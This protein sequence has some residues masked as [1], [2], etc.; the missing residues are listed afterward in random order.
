MK[1]LVPANSLPVPRFGWPAIGAKPGPLAICRPAFTKI[2]RSPAWRTFEPAFRKLPDRSRMSLVA[3][4]PSTPG[5]S[6]ECSVF[7]VQA[8]CFLSLAI[9]VERTPPL[10]HTLIGSPSTG[11]H[12]VEIPPRLPESHIP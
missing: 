5:N 4:W 2:V 8:V 9:S 12:P 3:G 6:G 11:I 1:G 7:G 10:T